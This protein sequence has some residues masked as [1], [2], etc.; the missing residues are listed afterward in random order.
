VNR[1]VSPTLDSAPGA[2]FFRLACAVEGGLALAAIL[3]GSWLG[4]PVLAGLRGSLADGLLGLVASLPLLLLFRILHTSAWTPLRDIRS[5]LEQVMEPALSGWSI[6]QMAVVSTLAGL[7]EECFF[8]GLLQSGLTGRTGPAT[9]LVLTSLLF[10]L[11]HRV[12]WPYAIVAALIGAY[13]G[14]LWLASAT[15]LVPV[16]AHATYDFLVLLYLLRLRHGRGPRGR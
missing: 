6:R 10:G 13:L 11:C 1:R 7:G 9:A 4:V 15:L 3:L 8:R 14:W 5:F 12:N 16:V 2:R